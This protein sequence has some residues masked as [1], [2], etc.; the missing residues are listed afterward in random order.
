MPSHTR[1]RGAASITLMILF[2]CLT[3]LSKP[4]SFYAM[5]ISNA[6][7]TKV[8]YINVESV[9]IETIGGKKKVNKHLWN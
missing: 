9:E 8:M 4:G 1:K 6:I 5:G 3:R 2:F 7:K